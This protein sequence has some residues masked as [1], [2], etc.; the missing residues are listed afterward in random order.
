MRACTGWIIGV[1][2][3]RAAGARSAR[4]FFFSTRPQYTP[5]TEHACP[6]RSSMRTERKFYE[7]D[8]ILLFW[9]GLVLH[10]A[11]LEGCFGDHFQVIQGTPN[12]V[13]ERKSTDFAQSRRVCAPGC[14]EYRGGIRM[15]RNVTF[16]ENHRFSA[17]ATIW[18]VLMPP[19]YSAHP[20]AQTH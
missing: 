4:I 3:P 5:P 12:V 8:G 11:M 16:A 1:N 18:G 2:P 9:R 6:H 17:K 14:A 13:G 15:L 19:R 10:S 7:E 20:S